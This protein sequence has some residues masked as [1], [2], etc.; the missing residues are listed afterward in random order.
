MPH[1][2][3]IINQYK[4]H[5]IYGNIKFSLKLYLLK[6][7]IIEV[8]KCNMI[9]CFNKCE[10][11]KPPGFGFTLYCN[12]H[13]NQMFLS[14]KE[15]EI[16]DWLKTIYNGKIEKNYRMF[17]NKELD[18]FIPNLNLGIEFNGLY[19]HS[20][21]HK[22]KQAHFEKFKFF[23][24]KNIKIITVWEDEWKDKQEIV[25]S[26]VKNALNL[27]LHKIDARK[28]I[29]KLVNNKDKTVFLNN[30]H[31]Q[32]NCQSKINLGLF[33]QDNLV[34]LMTFGNRRIITRNT[35]S[36]GHY[37]LLRFCSII[38]F[39]VRGAASK[40]FNFFLNNY[41]IKEILSY[42]NLD[43]GFGNLYKK[44][45][46]NFEGFTSINYW[47]SDYRYRYH[48]SGFMKHKLVKNYVNEDKTKVEIMRERGFERIWG[49]GNGKWIF[50]TNLKYKG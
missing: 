38:N 1:F 8:P 15:N 37:E 24:E 41:N 30:N 27:S 6:N 44:L 49:T 36:E 29:V 5:G 33:Y 14:K 21:K 7:K 2:Y 18:I 34:S 4:V 11:L 31:I 39:N 26:I 23:H 43:I 20:E 32:G 19:W 16:Y 13:K 28:C 40:L 42:S 17:G 48:R 35:P 12:K 22:N 50:K 3:K 10:L 25:K 9:S 46:F 45:G 47:W